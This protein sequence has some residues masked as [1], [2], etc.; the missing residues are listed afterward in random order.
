MGGPIVFKP[1]SAET[2]NN[3]A[4]YNGFAIWINVFQ[5]EMKVLC[6]RQLSGKKQC[7]I[8]VIFTVHTYICNTHTHV[9][10]SM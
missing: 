6:N 10:N 7:Q 9:Y 3:Y 2:A 5:T 1:F 4:T 8:S